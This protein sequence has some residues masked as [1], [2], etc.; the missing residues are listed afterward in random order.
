MY[1]CLRLLLDLAD[2]RLRVH[3]PEAELLL[4]R[5][6]LCV[7]RRQSK[8]PHLTTADRTIMALLSE[9]VNRVSSR[10]R[11]PVQTNLCVPQR[12]MSR[13]ATGVA[14]G[15]CLRLAGEWPSLPPIWVYG[16]RADDS[17]P[18][19]T[20]RRFLRKHGAVLSKP[21]VAGVRE[22]VRTVG[23]GTRPCELL[24]VNSTVATQLFVQRQR[25]SGGH[26]TVGAS[27]ISLSRLSNS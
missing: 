27:R 20:D 2:V 21:I 12:E 3:E 13:I 24:R 9:R 17:R 18:R 4:L 1:S 14:V 5:H 16:T 11:A 25:G 10:A 19:A 23:S 15:S 22:S 26:S 8:R 6:Q 7:L